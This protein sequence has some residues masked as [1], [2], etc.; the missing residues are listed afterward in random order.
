LWPESSVP[1]RGGLQGDPS[2][3]QMLTQLA[4]QHDTALV[5]G[6]PY[7]ERDASGTG[8]VSNAAFLIRA[9]GVWAGRYDKVHLVPWGEYVPVSWLFRF[10]APLVEGVAGFRRGDANQPLFADPDADI[11][12]FAM[13]ICYEIV[14]PGHLRRQVAGGATFIATITND[15]WFGE[16]S[17]PYQHFA[18]ARLRAVETRRYL[19][20]A[21]NTGIS[22]VIDPWGRVVHRTE[23]NKPA[24][25]IAAI[26]PGTSRTL[27]VRGGF[28]FAPL[29]VFL[30]VVGAI[31]AWRQS[32]RLQPSPKS[33]FLT[34]PGD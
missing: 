21:A 11:P 26:V 14:F 24:L 33:G 6:S 16:T 4:R 32:P 29:C 2:T 15:A 12:P 34:A 7:F 17:A 1:V 22:G 8:T 3:K 9:D 5:V 27:Y 23:L 20:R 18:M 30:A 10:V 25:T 31:M 28:V 19:V 13:A